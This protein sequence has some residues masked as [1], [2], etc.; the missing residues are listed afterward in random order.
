MSVV[1]NS[2]QSKQ[3]IVEIALGVTAAI[4]IIDLLSA[5]FSHHHSPFG[6]EG[7]EDMENFGGRGRQRRAER[8][9]LRER[10][11]KSKLQHI[12]DKFAARGEES[13]EQEQYDDGGGED[14]DDNGGEE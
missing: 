14:S 12:K 8:R 2:H 4:L 9:K 3:N 5:I 13:D 11:R 7:A 1:I 10:R 6:L